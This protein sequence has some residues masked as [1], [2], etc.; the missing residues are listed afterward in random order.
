MDCPKCGST[1]YC[2]DG[3][4]KDRQR[5]LCKGCGYRYTVNRRSGTADAKIK[6]QALQ[7]YL[8]GMGFRSIGRMLNF[9]NVSILKWIRSFGE[10]L[11]SIRSTESVQ[12]MEV[13]EM[14][15]YVGSKKTLAGSGLLLIEMREDSSTAYW[16]R[17][18]RSPGKSSG[19]P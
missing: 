11:E 10:Q 1:K 2:K 19:S 6:R 9:S 17:G 4:I 12:V 13:D 16:V 18:A 3:I 7:L 14:H 5:Y 15:S 8:E